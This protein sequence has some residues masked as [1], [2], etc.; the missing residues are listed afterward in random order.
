MVND[1]VLLGASLGAF[2]GVF[3][4]A[5]IIFY[6]YVAVCL[7]FIA[8]KT[9]TKNSWLAWIPFANVFL[10]TN[11][12][13]L[14]WGYALG[15]ILLPIIPFLGALVSFGLTIYAF[16]LVSE[17]RGVHGALSLLLII[18]IVNLIYLGYLAFKK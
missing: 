5:F 4:L 1:E 18:P 16:W 7:M 14:H 9:K 8:Q 12:A 3:L 10:I 13:G 2:F 15:I 11:V 6:I 17:K